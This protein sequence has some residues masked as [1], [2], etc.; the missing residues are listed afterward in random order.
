MQFS[1][2]RTFINKNLKHKKQ[3]TYLLLLAPCFLTGG[4]E[5]ARTA[6][7]LLAKQ[8]LSQLSYTPVPR[9]KMS[10]VRDKISYYYLLASCFLTG[11]P[12]WSRTTD[13]T[14][15]RRAL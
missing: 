9:A 5:R 10:E 7:L 1:K 15:I 14:L 6:D 13:L 8:A 11:G 12:K 2:N 4:D 3:E